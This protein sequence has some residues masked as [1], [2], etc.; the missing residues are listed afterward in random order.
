MFTWYRLE[1]LL[2]GERLF[3]RTSKG[4]VSAAVI[5]LVA[6]PVMAGLFPGEPLNYLSVAIFLSAFFFIHSLPAKQLKS[7]ELKR[8]AGIWEYVP[9]TFNFFMWPSMEVFFLQPRINR[10]LQNRIA[11]ED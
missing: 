4:K 5:I 2:A 9:A 7:I 6:S 11:I 10:L 1:Q 8:N 3:E